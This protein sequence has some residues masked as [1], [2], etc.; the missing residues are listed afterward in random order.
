[1]KH[2][3]LSLSQQASGAIPQWM[4][5]KECIFLRMRVRAS[6]VSRKSNESNECAK[7]GNAPL[8]SNT[9]TIS[10]CC[11]ENSFLSSEVVIPASRLVE[12]LPLG[13]TKL[14][15]NASI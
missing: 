12:N 7:R 2:S 4:T 5:E 1:M 13:K 14:G 3:S 8:E 15:M 11:D 10:C 6:A 9:C